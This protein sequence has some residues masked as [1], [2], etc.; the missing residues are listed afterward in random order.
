MS[1]WTEYTPRVVV[2]NETLYLDIKELNRHFNDIY[3]LLFDEI[4][5]E[6]FYKEDDFSFQY[7]IK[8]DDDYCIGG[9]GG[10][11]NYNNE[12][13]DNEITMYDE[14]EEYDDGDFSSSSSCSSSFHQQSSPPLFRTGSY[15]LNT[16]IESMVDK[17]IHEKLE[18]FVV[19]HISSSRPDQQFLCKGCKVN[20]IDVVVLDSHKKQFIAKYCKSCCEDKKVNNPIDFKKKPLF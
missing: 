14:D 5:E 8:E 18:S 13:D 4:Y 15:E 2:L 17:I 11:S 3:K 1:Y 9:G 12:N 16:L 20:H 7:N 10:S 19:K 6:L